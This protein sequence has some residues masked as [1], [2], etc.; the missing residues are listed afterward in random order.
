MSTLPDVTRVLAVDIA[1]AAIDI[2]LSRGLGGPAPVTFSVGDAFEPIS[3]CPLSRV[4]CLLDSV[5]FHCIIDDEEQRAYV[6]AITP[7]VKPGGRMVLFV[8]SDE[9]DTTTWRGPRC[10]LEDPNFCESRIYKKR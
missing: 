2:A 5:L 9:N 7:L 8:F 6:R 4:D 10:I 3:I 1:P